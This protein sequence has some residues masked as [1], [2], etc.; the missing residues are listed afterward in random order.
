MPEMLSITAILI[1][2]N[3][4]NPCGMRKRKSHAISSE[5]KVQRKYHK[6][7]KII[8]K[9]NIIMQFKTLPT[10]LLPWRVQDSDLKIFPSHYN[11]ERSA[12]VIISGD[13]RTHTSHAGGVCPKGLN[14]G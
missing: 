5:E 8:K 12:Y 4:A 2:K 3:D 11:L 14:Y 7:H 9:A 13:S 6:Y 10:A 1:I